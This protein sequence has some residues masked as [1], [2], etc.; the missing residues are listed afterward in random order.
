M[1][2]ATGEQKGIEGPGLSGSLESSPET[3]H[4]VRFVQQEGTNSVHPANQEARDKPTGQ[5][6]YPSSGFPRLQRLA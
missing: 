2:Q 1:A 3:L 4:R 6:S 5:I